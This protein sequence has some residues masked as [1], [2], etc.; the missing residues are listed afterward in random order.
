MAMDGGVPE[1]VVLALGAGVLGGPDALRLLIALAG[2]NPAVDIGM[3]SRR[4]PRAPATDPFTRITLLLSLA[5]AVLITACLVLV[6]GGPDSVRLLV[7]VAVCALVVAI[8]SGAR[9]S[10]DALRPSR[11]FTN[12]AIAVAVGAALLLL[13]RFYRRA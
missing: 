8:P 7:D 5:A 10:L 11:G 6:S 13:I 12:K 9:G 2:R 4:V 3:R 1:I